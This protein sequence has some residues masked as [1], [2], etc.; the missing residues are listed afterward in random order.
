MVEA[1]RIARETD[2]VAALKLIFQA[3]DWLP[4]DDRQDGSGADMATLAGMDA[5]Q[6]REWM[7]GARA[8]DVTPG[9]SQSADEAPSNS[10]LAT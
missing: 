4:R 1:W 6:L 2:S 5:R 8:L 10:Q 3:N 7:R 9:G